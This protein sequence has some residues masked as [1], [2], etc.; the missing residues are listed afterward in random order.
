MI[1]PQLLAF[2]RA[3][4]H[5]LQRNVVVGRDFDRS[6][7]VMLFR[8]NSCWEAKEQRAAAVRGCPRA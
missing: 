4:Y 1:H 3:V 8:A 5:P 2:A 7:M 6:R